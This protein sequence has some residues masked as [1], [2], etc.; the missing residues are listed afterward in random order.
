MANRQNTGQAKMREGMDKVY[1]EIM[2]F[3]D[4][5]EK[6]ANNTNL[7]A[8]NAAIEAAR[9]G[10]AGRGFGVVATEVRTLANAISKNA[11]DLSTTVFERIRTQT[12]ELTEEFSKRDNNRLTEMS[13]SLVQLI[14]RNLFERTADVRWWAT[15]EAFYHC[16]ENISDESKAHAAKRLGVIN[17]FYTVYINLVLADSQ[18]NVVAVSA[19]ENYSGG[20]DE[21]V[22]KYEWFSKALATTAGD[23]Y[24]VADIFDCPIHKNRPVAVYSTAVRRGGELRG[25]VL[26]VLGVF[27][28]WQEQSDVIVRDEP[29]LTPEEWEY[30]RVLLLDN[31]GRIIAASDGQDL[32]KKFSPAINT[33]EEKGH[34]TK[35]GKLIAYA[36]TC[37]YEDYDGLGWYGVIVQEA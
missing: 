34:F 20:A 11:K 17:K 7:L 30:S 28:D 18:G 13:L 1:N 5:V 3:A 35:E 27:F 2:V 4:F 14:V 6:T 25:A 33:G 15:D 26:G 16:L 23:Q 9:A 21:N 31:A 10:E 19:P 32:Y 12:E 29:N 8:L 36:K 37:G 22:A 24:H